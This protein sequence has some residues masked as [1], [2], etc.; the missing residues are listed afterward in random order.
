[1]KHIIVSILLIL[2]IMPDVMAQKLLPVYARYYNGD[3]AWAHKKFKK[4][5]KKK[6]EPYA[7]QYGLAIC[8]SPWQKKQ[9]F[10]EFKK[11]DAKFRHSGKDFTRYN[12]II[13]AL[14]AIR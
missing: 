9:A 4:F 8:I 5:I 11:L 2:W 7:A 3:T 1:M 12:L 13:M 14:H 10:I 6:R